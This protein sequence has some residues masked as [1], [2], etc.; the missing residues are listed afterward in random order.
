M[1]IIIKKKK[2]KLHTL[3]KKNAGTARASNGLDMLT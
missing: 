2:K 1:K 3:L